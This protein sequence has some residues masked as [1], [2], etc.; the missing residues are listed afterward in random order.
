M[1]SINLEE[2]Y[3]RQQSL[4]AASDQFAL[5]VSEFY[6]GFPVE[7]RKVLESTQNDHK[8]VLQLLTG[9]QIRICLQRNPENF[10]IQAAAYREINL[11]FVSELTERDLDILCT[12]TSQRSVSF[13]SIPGFRDL[14]DQE[15]AY[16]KEVDDVLGKL[17]VITGRVAP[18][19]ARKGAT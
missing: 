7:K 3:P 13:H 17:L 14:S 11:S 16:G 19:N 18:E 15:E 5:R 8:E 9:R 12:L 4:T 1:I 6:G 2:T 10:E